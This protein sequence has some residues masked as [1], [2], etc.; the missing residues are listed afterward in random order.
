MKLHNHTLSLMRQCI[1]IEKTTLAHLIL[2][3]SA[4]AKIL[5]GS[6]LAT[7]LQFLVQTGLGVQES[8]Q[9]VA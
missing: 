5:F 4:L 6:G 3:L 2:E 9:Q 1:V 8:K 7:L